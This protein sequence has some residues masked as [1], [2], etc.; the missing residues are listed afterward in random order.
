MIGR[1]FFVLRVQ[2]ALCLLQAAVR[3]INI[4]DICPPNREGCHERYL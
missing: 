2:A 1:F 4:I 3:I